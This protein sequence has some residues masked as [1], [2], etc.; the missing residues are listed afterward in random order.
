MTT[1]HAPSADDK[2]QYESPPDRRPRGGLAVRLLA[3]IA[4]LAVALGVVTVASLA[5]F[6]DTDS[7]PN[8]TFSTGTVNIDATPDAT[9]FTAPSM[10]PGDE[11]VAPITV[12]N[13]G[14]MQL[15]YAVTSETSEDVLA[16]EL[17][18]TIR[19]NVTDCS[20]ANWDATGTQVYQGILGDSTTSGGLPVLGSAAAGADAGDRVLNGGL[21][22]A[23]C[24][25]VQLPLTATAQG[26][27]TTA[28]FNFLAEQTA[29][30]P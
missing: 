18:L 26:A 13:T 8:N 22:E 7:V 27:T 5:L 15:R 29:N 30:N 2:Q 14:S 16:S 19:D 20:V 11:V 6:T 24:F 1:I 4:V 10:N 3:S 28:I 9:V 17:V 12:A 25:H 23:L 21:N